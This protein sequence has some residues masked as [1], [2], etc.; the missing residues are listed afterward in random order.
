MHNTINF[1][2]GN[3]EKVCMKRSWQR[4]DAKKGGPALHTNKNFIRNWFLVYNLGYSRK[5]MGFEHIRFWKNQLEFLVLLFHPWKFW[6]KQSYSSLKNNAKLCDT[7]WEWNQILCVFFFIASENF[8][9]LLFSP[10]KFH[11]VFLQ[12]S[13]K[14]P[15]PGIANFV[16]SL[17]QT[18]YW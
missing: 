9:Y 11:I 12:Y 7:Y 5:K 14:N 3:W 8:S 2:Y 1:W 4:E 10:R 17:D 13:F 6:T 15:S 18:N 16:T